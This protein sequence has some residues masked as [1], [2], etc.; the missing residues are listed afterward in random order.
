VTIATAHH[1]RIR[2]ANTSV[3]LAHR[4]TRLAGEFVNLEPV[5]GTA[6]GW[7]IFANPAGVEQIAR[8]V[9]VLTGIAM[10]VLLGPVTPIG[11]RPVSR[12]DRL[13]R[14]RRSARPTAHC[15]H[16]MS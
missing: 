4:V 7:L 11:T 12:Q 8:A 3:R 6:Q 16:G 10:S 14:V 2:R 5:V 15:A 1:D 13:S 9:G